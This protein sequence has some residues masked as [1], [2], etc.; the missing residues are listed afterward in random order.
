MQSLASNQGVCV[1]FCPAGPVMEYMPD[2]VKQVPSTAEEL[3]AWA[4]ANPNRFMY[5]RPANSG[6]GRVFM[7]GLPYVLGDKDPHDPKD[8]W[9]KTWAYLRSSASTSSTIRPAP[10]R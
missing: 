9:A 6:P 3:L 10:A 8:G 7:M 5:A 2:K 1:V 4:K